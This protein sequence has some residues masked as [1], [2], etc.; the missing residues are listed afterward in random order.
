M[1]VTMDTLFGTVK[2][3][4][5]D[6]VA[7]SRGEIDMPESEV[8]RSMELTKAILENRGAQALEGDDRANGEGGSQKAAA[9]LEVPA[10][11]SEPE[12]LRRRPVAASE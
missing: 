7:K 1:T 11:S 12:I 10:P 2:H 3:P 9:Q 4:R 6:A 5:K 8:R